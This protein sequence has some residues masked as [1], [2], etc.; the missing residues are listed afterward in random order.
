VAMPWVGKQLRDALTVI[1]GVMRGTWR[2][3]NDRQVIAQ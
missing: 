2:E 1:C 3:P